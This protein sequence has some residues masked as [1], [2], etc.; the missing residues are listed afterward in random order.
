MHVRSFQL[1][2]VSPVTDLL[3][4]ALS[5]ECFENTIEPFSRQ[6]SWDSDLIVVAEDEDEIVGAL[7][8]TIEKNHGCYFRIAVHPDYR[9]RGVGRSLVSAMES[10][11]QAR[12]V[13]DIYLAVDEHNSFALPLY[14]AMGYSENQIIKSVRKLSIVG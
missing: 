2:D 9:R 10:R 8:G 7:I 4:T 11:F 3:Q 14:E 6:L 1:S 12:K 5:E 13:S